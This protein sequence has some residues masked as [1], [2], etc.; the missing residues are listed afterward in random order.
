MVEKIGGCIACWNIKYVLAAII[1]LSFIFMSRFIQSLIL[2]IKRAM[3][4]KIG[5]SKITAKKRSK[6]KN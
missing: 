5:T 6:N 4:P 3:M 2:N 1:I